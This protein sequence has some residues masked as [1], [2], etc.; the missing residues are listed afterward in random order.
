MLVNEKSVVVIGLCVSLATAACTFDIDVSPQDNDGGDGGTEGGNGGSGGTLAG[1]GGSN[2]GSGGTLGGSAGSDGGAGGSTSGLGGSGGSGGGGTA[3]VGGST[4]GSGGGGGAGGEGCLPPMHAVCDTVTQCG[5]DAGENCHFQWDDGDPVRI[6]LPVGSAGPN[7]SCSENADCVLG[8]GCV[9]GVCKQYCHIADDCGW[10]DARCEP[11]EVHDEPAHPEWNVCV[12]HCDVVAP[13]NPSPG[14]QACGS[15]AT[16]IPLF[17]SE[18]SASSTECAPAGEGA[19]DEPCVDDSGQNDPPCGAGLTCEFGRCLKWCDLAVH[20]C[21][22]DLPC[23]AYPFPTGRTVTDRNLGVCFDGVLRQDD[24]T[25]DESWPWMSSSRP[26]AEAGSLDGAYVIWLFWDDDTFTSYASVYADDVVVEV[27]ARSDRSGNWPLDLAEQ[28]L[29]V[30]CR[31]A[32]VFQ[33][34]LN[35]SAR[36]L[37]YDYDPEYEYESC[38]CDADDYDCYYECYYQRCICDA[39][40]YDCY[41]RCYYNLYGYDADPWVPLTDWVSSDAIRPTEGNHIAASCVGNSPVQLTLYV[42]GQHVLQLEESVYSEP[43]G[44]VGLLVSSFDSGAFGE[45]DNLFV[46]EP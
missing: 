40:D 43:N 5:C 23:V 15:G 36:I 41:Y 17:E 25:D 30:Y 42:N 8:H 34:R 38:I 20:E 4:S 21:P 12:R 28:A 31:G 9:D 24:F 14:F 37:A 7:S 10:D 19:V 45:F 11:V 18:T 1:S 6:C 32:Y 27:D 13:N 29:G 39:D 46:W 16:C 2:G 33:V 44:S 26:L 3:G 35:G 22:D